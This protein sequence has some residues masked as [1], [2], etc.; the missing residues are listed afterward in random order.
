MFSECNQ[1][2]KHMLYY[3][4][5]LK[6]SAY[7]KTP[8]FYSMRTNLEIIK[9]CK[10]VKFVLDQYMPLRAVPTRSTPTA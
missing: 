6:T 4:S 1:T 8:D 10:F 9:T 2:L 5:Y 7:Y 3:E